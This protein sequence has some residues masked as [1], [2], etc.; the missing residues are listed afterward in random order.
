M[1]KLLLVI[2]LFF[3]AFSQGISQ[4]IDTLS[5]DKTLF[6]KELNQLFAET[7][8]S[9]LSDLSK[10]FETQIK[11]GLVSD[12]VIDKIRQ[13]SNKML[14]MRGKAYPQL[15]SMLSYYLELNKLE[16]NGA[17]WLDFQSVLMQVMNNSKKGDTKSSLDFIEFAIPLFRENA[18]FFST[19]K[20]WKLSNDKFKLRYAEEGPIVVSEQCDIIGETKGDSIKILNTAGTFDYNSKMWNGTKGEVNWLKAG[21]PKDEVYASFGAYQINTNTQAYAIPEVTFTYKNYFKTSLKGSLDDK[22]TT[23][24]SSQTIRFPRF[25][26]DSESVPPQEITPNVVYYGGFTLA[27][28]KVL[29]GS[30]NEKSLLVV[31]KENS[32]VKILSALSNSITINLPEKISSSNAQISLYFD[33]DSIYHPCIDL[34]Y[35]LTNNTIKLVKGDG[36][37]SQSSFTDSYHNV[38]FNVDVIT[39]NLNDDFMNLNTISTSGIKAATFESKEYFS[40]QKMKELRGNVSYDPLSILRKEAEM[41]LDNT[42]YADVF[43]KKISP[44]LTVQQIKP[45]LFNL[46]QEGFIIYNEETD[47]ITMRPKVEHYVKANAKKKDFD[48]IFINSNT[49][50]D[51]A[52]LNLAKR[53]LELEGVKTVPISIATS[54]Y[55]F[56]DSQKITIEKNRD[57]LFNGLLFCG[58][59]DFW[60]KNNHFLYED[61][62][63]DLP[64]IDTMIMNIPDGDKIDNYG[65]PVLRPINSTLEGLRGTLNINIPINKSGSSELAQF[66]IFESLDKSRVYYDDP[67]IRNGTYARD[68][69]YYEIEPFT[70]DSLKYLSI[71]NLEFGG[72][73]YSAGIFPDL[74]QSLKVQSDLSLGFELS[75]PPEGFEV[76]QGKGKFI[77]DITLNNTGLTGSGVIKYKTTSFESR[78]IAFYPD[79]MMAITDTFGIKESKGAYESPWVKSSDNKI[80]WYPYLDSMVAYSSNINPFEMF[81]DKIKLDGILEI[82]NKGIHGSG[83][84][85]WEDAQLISNRFQFK[86]DE[87]LADTAELKIKTIDGDKVTFNT[88]NVNASVDFTKNTGYFKSNTDEN[89]TEF[90][91]NQYVTT[92]DEFFW[93][94]DNKQLKFSVPQ[95]S[96]GAPFVSMNPNQDSLM[97][98]A[99]NADY[100]LE[101]SIIEAYGVSEIFVAD[102]R[103]IP[104]EGKVVVL[105]EAKM[106]PLSN[107]TIEASTTTKKHIIEQVEVTVNGKNDINA[108]GMYKYQAKNTPDQFVQLS[109]I[110]IILADSSMLDKKKNQVISH[111]IHAKGKISQ[112][113]NFIVYPDVQYY[114]D[115]EM[116][117]SIDNLNIKGYTKVDFKNDY[118]VSDFFQVDGKVD[119]ESLNLTLDGAKDPTGKAIRTGIFVNKIGIEP[120]YTNILNNQIGPLD[121]AMIEANGILKHNSINNIYTFGSEEKMNSEL[122]VKGNILVFDPKKNTIEAEGSLDFSLA[123]GAID[124]KIAG[125]VKS[126][127]EQNE[128]SFTTSIALPLEL[129]NN[130]LERIAYYLYED[131]FDLEDVSYDKEEIQN[132]WVELLSPKSFEKM[133]QEI[134]S[135]G[136]F[137][138]P[139]DLKESIVFT[140]IDMTYDPVERV[141][142]S[143]GKFGLAF[144][145]EKAIHKK[146]NGY[147]EFGHRMGSDYM[148]IYLKTSFNDYV[149]ISF[150]TTLMEI[151]SSFD[152]V[153]ASINAVDVTKRKIKGENNAYYVYVAGNEMKAKAYLQ[154]M[155]IL[156]NGGTLP[157]PDPPMEKPMDK[158]ENGASEENPNL[159]EGETAPT[160]PEETEQ[161]EPKSKSKKEKGNNSDEEE[162]TEVE[163]TEESAP[164]PQQA[165]PQ[166]VLDFEENQGK[167]KKNKN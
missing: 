62:N 124:E 122:P 11:N 77:S 13:A 164:A 57:M 155:K 123:Y 118:V 19:A 114:G 64:T 160:S 166:E 30:E 97:F 102:S 132:Q 70:L 67:S 8:R 28:S 140:D 58:R 78:N 135:T 149:F 167:G 52:R 138:R 106:Q 84:A 50:G 65:N 55:F 33:K 6:V 163:E 150:T 3:L 59:L 158:E 21:L 47:L 25:V 35:N 130:V 43:A 68:K 86:S 88:P 112:A 127:L 142:R 73:L 80:E 82:T 116:F 37:L 157:P 15:S 38:E 51:N 98:I 131:N 54:T 103:I 2:S 87:L 119:P 96:T 100:S 104:N 83:I 14:L 120:I 74:N 146:I 4:V 89:R 61:F 9:E 115:I 92:I 39:W 26:A 117:S 63:M 40:D 148:N 101:T 90:N 75:S 56:P 94:I 145:G 134:N 1:K 107:A 22:M 66:P 109:K 27:G 31:Y 151:S 128:Y 144:V 34:F 133:T 110:E 162:T 126:N 36:S 23:S 99:T 71:R 46:V 79:S 49:K 129:D 76:Y 69:F 156:E 143:K 16:L 85:D 72:K 141:Y 91:Y 154:R 41:N 159:E 105:P 53:T 165:I 42:I 18:I 111:I 137:A 20:T 113:E 108:S 95:G 45:L 44:Q 12:P 161:E 48:N 32:K 24:T 147:L 153:I 152:D 29:G 7:K 17:E 93:D 60:G 121:V 81:G 125:Q 139:K 136:L 10:E 5:A